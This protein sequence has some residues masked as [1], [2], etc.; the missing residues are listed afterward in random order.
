MFRGRSRH[1]LDPKGRLAI[2]TRFKDALL[3]EDDGCLIVTN[4]IE[5]LLAFGRY[6]WNA[7]EEQASKLPP[8][9]RRA[10][11]YL[12]YFISGAAECR[13]KQGRITI[14]PDLRER[15]GLN[16]E[17]VLV[18]QL[19]RFEIWDREKWDEEFE[20]VKASFPEASQELSDLG[21]LTG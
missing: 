2:P 16:K 13:I 7:V 3:P 12:R 4:G 21:I 9:D 19:K 11:A 20:R 15:A 14:H 10:N 8:F 5:C 6:S 18:G 17:V 1:T